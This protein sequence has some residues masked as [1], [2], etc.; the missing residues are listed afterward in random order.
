MK[1]GPI[2]KERLVRRK[3]GGLVDRK[4]GEEIKKPEAISG[5]EKE[6]RGRPTKHVREGGILIPPSNS[7]EGGRCAFLGAMNGVYGVGPM[8]RVYEYVQGKGRSGR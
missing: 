6:G 5:G 8:K 4:R 3:A 2:E 7:S 1:G